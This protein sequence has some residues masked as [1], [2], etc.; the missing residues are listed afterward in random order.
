[1]GAKASAGGLSAAELVYLRDDLDSMQARGALPPELA[2]LRIR[3]DAM[4][5]LP[6]S[7]ST[8]P[9]SPPPPAAATPTAGAA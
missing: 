1:M 5:A 3:L 4:L 7:A 8:S 6:V 9:P 2:A